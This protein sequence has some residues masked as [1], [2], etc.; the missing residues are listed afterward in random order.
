MWKVDRKVEMR[1]E[2]GFWQQYFYRQA[3]LREAGVRL[4]RS[5]LCRLQGLGQFPR[6]FTRPGDHGYYLKSEVDAWVAQRRALAAEVTM[7]E[8]LETQ[9]QNVA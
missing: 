8:E 1:G 7:E 5:R 2:I 9:D 3:D 4:S 6:P